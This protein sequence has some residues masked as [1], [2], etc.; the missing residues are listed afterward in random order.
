MQPAPSAIVMRKRQRKEEKNNFDYDT[1][2]HQVNK[3][4]PAQRAF[5]YECSVCHHGN[6]QKVNIEKHVRAKHRENTDAC[7]IKNTQKGTIHLPVKRPEVLYRCM[8]CKKSFTIKTNCLAHIKKIHLDRQKDIFVFDELSPTPEQTAISDPL[9]A[10]SQ[11]EKFE[12]PMLS[13][14]EIENILGSMAN[15]DQQDF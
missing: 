13:D 8:V 15:D 1:I 5:A 7:V 3:K 2:I 9:S 11:L 10:P 14:A 6:H 4:T 12:F